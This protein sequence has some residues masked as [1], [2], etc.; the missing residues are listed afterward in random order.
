[1]SEL[2]IWKIGEPL[3]FAASHFGETYQVDKWRNAKDIGAMDTIEFLLIADLF[4]RIEA[5]EFVAF[6]FRVAPIV[7]DG[8]VRIPAHA[9]EPRPDLDLT[10]CD[11]LHVSGHSYER[12]RIL[13]ITDLEKGKSAKSI[14]ANSAGRRS[15][16]ADSKIVIEFLF[17]N[18]SNRSKS[19][20]KLHPDFER[21]FLRR[22]PLG[23][24]KIAPPSE[25]T[26]RNHLKRYRQEL[27]EMD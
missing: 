22:F 5:G 13:P 9:F 14:S 26:L 6:G 19:A 24:W 11:K 1:M 16:Y 7:S 21:E 8:P 15:T 18:K 27:E 4:G 2:E 3:G 25:R 12:I 23:E 20:A 10:R 17:Q